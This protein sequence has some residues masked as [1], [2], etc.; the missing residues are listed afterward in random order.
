MPNGKPLISVITCTYNDKDF[1]AE[2]IESIL[3]Q[4]FTDFEYIIVND[5]S[6]DGTA[7]IL[8][9]YASKDDRI[10][11]ITNKENS[12]TYVSANN[13]LE[14][15][16]GKYVARIDGDDVAMPSRFEKQVNFLK[17]NPHKI[18]RLV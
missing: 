12:G 15:A 1:I 14:V 17:E 2:T 11:I 9:E 7:E 16:Q 3:N 4:T 10:K 13:A 8:K 18:P 5:V 6:N